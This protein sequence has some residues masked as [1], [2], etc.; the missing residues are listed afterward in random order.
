M[1]YSYSFVI[2]LP[3]TAQYTF[4]KLFVCFLYAESVHITVTCDTSLTFK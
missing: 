2:D 1:V 3:L 4:Y